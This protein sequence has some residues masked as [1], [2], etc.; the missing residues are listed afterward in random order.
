MAQTFVRNFDLESIKKT[1]QM[2]QKSVGDVSCVIWDAAIVLSK[3]LEILCSNN[4]EYL[5]NKQVIELGAGLGCAG[6]VA[7]C[8]GAHVTMTDLPEVL[9]NLTNN[10][11]YN[12]PIWESCGGSAQAKPL[13]W[14][15]SD[16]DTFSPP[17]V[18][19][20]T[21]CVYYKES[22]EPLVQTMVA[23]SSDKTEVIVCQ[24]ERDTDQQQHAW[25]LFT[26]LFTKHFQY[27][28]VPLRDQ[29]SLYSTDE[30]VILRGKKKSQL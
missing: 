17:D 6:L 20:A 18:L 3:Y 15:S 9:E 30:I 16:I 14:G 26:E 4:Q 29:H 2:Q 19:I 28:K 25:K 21:D 11:E 5:K 27:I 24:E 7:S 22:V 23:L 8:F 10:I 1:L 12:K 13:K